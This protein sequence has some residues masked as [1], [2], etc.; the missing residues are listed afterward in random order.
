MPV[1]SRDVLFMLRAQDFASREIRNVANSFNTIGK[2][3]AESNAQFKAAKAAQVAQIDAIRTVQAVDKERHNSVIRNHAAQAD[4]LR[5]ENARI[6]EAITLGQVNANRATERIRANDV[7]IAQHSLMANEVRRRIAVEGEGH[8][9]AIRQAQERIKVAEADHRLSRDALELEQQ[10]IRSMFAAGAAFTA[11]GAAGLVAGIGILSNLKDAVDVAAEFRQQVAY[12]STQTQDMG[13]NMDAVGDIIIRTM[14]EI[15]KGMDELSEGLYDIFSTIDVSVSSAEYLLNRFAKA[16]VAGQTDVRTASRATIAIMNAYQIP[17]SQVNELLDKQFELV[18]IGGGEYKDFA[19]AL[20]KLIP[21][22]QG[23]NQSIDSVFGAL[24]FL[25][26]GGMRA[27]EAA[28]SLGRALELMLNPDAIENLRELG[29]EVTN[30]EGDFR[31]LNDILMEIMTEGGFAALEQGEWNKSLEILFGEKG[32]VQARRFFERIREGMED[33]GYRIDQIGSSAGAM[34]AAFE[35]MAAQPLSKMQMLENS[36]TTLKI[37]VGEELLPVFI[38]IIDAVASLVREF[39]N[40]PP[41]VRRAIVIFVAVSGVFLTVMGTIS[42]LIGVTLLL[43]A[44]L[45]AVGRDAIKSGRMVAIGL[46]SLFLLAQVGALIATNWEETK[47]L[48]RG[49]WSSMVENAAAIWQGIYDAIGAPVAQTVESVIASLNVMAQAFV[50]GLQGILN[51]VIAFGQAIYRALQW[52]N[53]FA[54]HSPSLVENVRD[55]VDAILSDFARLSGVVPALDNATSAVQRLKR[56]TAELQAYFDAQDR[57]QLVEYLN[58]AGPGAVAAYDNAMRA[59]DALEREMEKIKTEYIAQQAVLDQLGARLRDATEEYERLE[60]ALEKLERRSKELERVVAEEERVLRSLDRTLRDAERAYEEAARPIE[61]MEDNLKG[62]NREL[63]RQRRALEVIQRSLS[64]AQR[65]YDDAATAVRDI[66]GELKDA[67][68]AADDFANAALK[69]TKKYRD[70][71]F[72]LDQQS[73]AIR[74]QMIQWEKVGAPPEALDYFRFQ[75]D[76]I[77]LKAEETRLDEQLELDPLRKQLEDAADASKELTFEEAMAGIVAARDRINELER[78]LPAATAEMLKKE[79][80]L[81]RVQKKYDEQS[82]AV[83]RASI[84]VEKIEHKIEEFTASLAPYQD[85]IDEA[86]RAVEDQQYAVDNARDALDEYNDSIEGQRQAV[87]D[88]KDAM[89][90][91]QA[92]YDAQEDVLGNLEQAYRDLTDEVENYKKA[93]DEAAALGERRLKEIEEAAKAAK[94]KK[95]PEDPLAGI[96]GLPEG[97]IEGYSNVIDDLEG[98]LDALDPSNLDEVNMSLAEFE[99]LGRKIGDIMTIVGPIIAVVGA[100]KGMGIVMAGV[101]AIGKGVLAVLGFLGIVLGVSATA[102]GWIVVAIGALVGALIYLWNTNE[103]FREFFINAWEH[104]RTFALEA[105]QNYIYPAF[106]AIA[107]FVTGT[108]IPTFKRL[109]EHAKTIWKNISDFIKA[110]WDKV[111]YPT[112]K[113]IVDFVE[114]RIVPVIKWLWNRVKDY[115]NLISEYIKFSWSVI[116]VIFQA[117]WTFIDGFLVPIFRFFWQVAR[118]IWNAVFEVIRA[119]WNK[120]KDIWNTIIV[121]I[122]D[123][124]APKFRWLRDNV[125]APVWDAIKEKISDIWGKIKPIWDA[126]KGFIDDTLRPAFEDLRD[127]W[128]DVWDAMGDKISGVWET[129]K[130]GVRGSINSVLGFIETM[131]NSSIGGINKVAGALNKLPGPDIIATIAP[132]SMPR[133]AVGGDVTRG[134]LAVVGEHGPEPVWLPAGASVSRR[135][136]LEAALAAQGGTGHPQV[137]IEEGAFQFNGPVD[138][139]TLPQVE[140]MLLDF[141]G[142]VADQMRKN[143]AG[144]D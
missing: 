47:A 69:G 121:W 44:A 95:G 25:T 124:L 5:L 120:I 94:G 88:A 13:A 45:I 6:R 109:W 66:E 91:A 78:A 108:L 137:T 8:A 72:G 138:S 22:A 43:R 26:R 30:A 32:R 10:R 46:G 97:S 139:A 105:W 87:E 128:R 118:T 98:Q 93:I 96:R 1:S 42:A 61:R 90:E 117:I 60:A 23:A 79:A 85:A 49:I 14:Q 130:E 17:V 70:A 81:D 2:Q 142:M 12:V 100:I 132:V 107:D 27:N 52:L 89:D 126:I 140:E 110:A 11:M 36:L 80:V 15:P 129:I 9:T 20:G 33:L 38:P 83:E 114:K 102:V 141:A 29:I 122:N 55:G 40:L 16:A 65:E 21:V 53:P 59:I 19:D 62:A 127:T 57:A 35:L 86:A 112:V 64:A 51:I 111:I 37:L 34:N 54:R 4:A 31:Q 84:A 77:A 144:D 101:T 41:Q 7:E 74:K 103:G 133:L 106:R 39:T 3:V 82:L 119:A 136:T 68:R 63:D 24:S 58:L 143:S 115:W 76:E 67:E 123:K 104:I 28:T 92:A 48:L 73:A 75:L 125:I 113:A 71:L 99:E 134:G 18:R 131:I 56:E 116:K 135:S 50:A